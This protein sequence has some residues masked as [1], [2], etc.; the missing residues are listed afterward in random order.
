MW[1]NEGPLPWVLFY[2]P[3][4]LNV[5]AMQV[6]QHESTDNTEVIFVR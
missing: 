5:C 2:I 3:L 6:M 1:V 4:M